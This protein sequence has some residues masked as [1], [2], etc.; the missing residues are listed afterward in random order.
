MRF[1]L[2]ALTAAASLAIAS[3]A[4]AQ[5]KSPAF[6]YWHVWTDKN[7]VDHQSRCELR[8]FDLKSLS[9]PAKPSWQD[10][11]KES[12]SKTIVTV[13]PSGWVGTWHKNPKAQWI[14]PLS[15]H[16]FVQTMDGKR[17]EMGPGDLS[18]GEDQMT[19]ADAGGHDGHLSGTVGSGPAVLMLVQLATKPTIDDPCRF[20]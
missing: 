18:F 14:I 13:L 7:G 10:V 6:P 3:Q 12:A 16:W 2:L 9:R 5:D 4:L 11:G 1:Y 17:V 8:D 15:G 20:K 19:K